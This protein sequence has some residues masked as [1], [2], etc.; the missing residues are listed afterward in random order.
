MNCDEFRHQYQLLVDTQSQANLPDELARHFAECRPCNNFARAMTAVDE[1]LRDLP[2]DPVP[3]ALLEKLYA[4]PGEEMLRALSVK[5]YVLKGAAYTLAALAVVGI[6]T[7]L[8]AEQQFW[9]P[10]ILLTAGYTMLIASILKHK[11]LSNDFE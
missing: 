9:P 11:R 6:G 1:A 10:L 7:W 8:P 3:E 4:I 5:N 2:E